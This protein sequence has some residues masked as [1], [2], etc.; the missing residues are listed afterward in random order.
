MTLVKP[1]RHHRIPPQSGFGF[2][3]KCGQ[4]LRVTAPQAEQVSDLF[5]VSQ[6]DPKVYF[7]AA[8]TIDYASTINPSEGDVLYANNSDPLMTIVADTA[9]AHDL[10]FA[11]CSPEMFQRTYPG[12]PANHPSCFANLSAALAPFGVAPHLITSTLNIFM[13][14]EILPGGTTHIHPPSSKA[15]DYMEQRAETD[16]FV[17]VTSCS[18]EQTNNGT[19]KPIDI[20]LFDLQGS[21]P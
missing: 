12:N 21:H 6:A 11:P 9:R 15:G 4:I 18:A 2:A 17:G 7:S 10:L 3:M 13:K 19:F 14:I 5:C 20:A 1:I 16:L 8:R